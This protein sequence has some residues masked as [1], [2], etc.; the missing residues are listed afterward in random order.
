[1][2]SPSNPLAALSNALTSQVAKAAPRVAALHMRHG[3]HLTATLWRADLVVASDQALP[4]RERFPV[5][6]A[7]GT[8]TE[9][10]ETEAQVIGRDDGSNIALLR[11][12]TA[13]P[14]ETPQAGTARTGALALAVG[15]RRDGAA[16]ACLGV[17]NQVGPSWHSQTG[18]RIDAYI[19]VDLGMAA[20]EEGGPVLDPD[21]GVVG[22]S[23]F[24]PRG[25]VIV[26]PHATIERIIPQL[27]ESGR[28][29]RGWI[30]AAL[31]P[32]AVPDLDEDLPP[33][34]FMIVSVVEGGPAAAAGLNPGDIIITAGGQPLGRLHGLSAHIIGRIGQTLELGIVR[35]LKA[36]GERVE[37]LT[38]T[39][40]E[41]P[42][43]KESE[44]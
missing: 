34:G 41:R 26:I 4:R 1:M 32:I 43:A 10:P 23:T 40:A 18:G 2:T 6:L 24:G 12:D 35:P 17:V 9:A 31:Q 21:G 37:T 14:L 25:Q 30:G 15:A 28:V 13:T 42:A 3:R 7:D 19:K 5:T 38:L 29:A 36:K 39:I 11:L 33:R 44:E 20:S 22:I 16:S 27:L 8:E